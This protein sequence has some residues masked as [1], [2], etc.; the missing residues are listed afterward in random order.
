MKAGYYV[1]I[2]RSNRKV[3]ISPEYEMVEKFDVRYDN[4]SYPHKWNL[5]IFEFQTKEEAREFGVKV[6]TKLAG[7]PKVSTMARN[8]SLFEVRGPIAGDF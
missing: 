2:D 1:W 6:A 7:D 4:R 3:R 5:E 8:T